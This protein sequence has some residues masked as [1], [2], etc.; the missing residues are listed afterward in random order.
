M[1]PSPV[2]DPQV[3]LTCPASF[4]YR[5]PPHDS[6]CASTAGAFAQRRSPGPPRRALQKTSSPMRC[7]PRPPPHSLPHAEPTPHH[8]PS[9]SPLFRCEKPT[10]ALPLQ[11]IIPL[12]FVH[13]RAP[14]RPP[15]SPLGPFDPPW[16]LETLPPRRNRAVKLPPPPLPP[17]ASSYVV[18]LLPTVFYP[19][20]H[21]TAV[22]RSFPIAE[23]MPSRCPALPPRRCSTATVSLR[24]LEAVRRIPRVPLMLYPPL[25]LHQG[26]SSP[27]AATSPC[28]P[29]RGDQRRS[30]RHTAQLGQPRPLSSPG[31]AAMIVWP[32]RCHRP[33]VCEVLEPWA[34]NRSVTV[35]LFS[36]LEFIYLFLEICSR[37]K[38]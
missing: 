37:F 31:W 21:P 23:Q 32:A 7:S 4:P 28:A 9:L 22:H 17:R 8:S 11:I 18:L 29:M 36:N 24:R 20:P 38:N 1:A 35:H 15:H 33:L 6:P 3:R 5:T 25:P 2:S 14:S 16:L 30:A 10:T 34:W 13:P 12:H 26:P 27:V 19:P